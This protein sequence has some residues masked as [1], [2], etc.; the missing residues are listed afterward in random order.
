[1]DATDQLEVADGVATRVMGLHP[2]LAVLELIV[3]PRSS[4]QL[5]SNNNKAQSG[6]LEIRANGN[7]A[8]VVYLE[9]ATHRAGALDRIQHYKAF[10]V[11]L[12]PIR[13]K[14]SLGM[15]RAQC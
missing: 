2:Q 7:G 12:N 1:M 10:D 3:Y 15:A 13:A 9:Q 6:T 5:Q 11:N 8:D 4:T 14:I